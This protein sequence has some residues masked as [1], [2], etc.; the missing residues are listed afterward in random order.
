MKD[1]GGQELLCSAAQEP[2]DP[3]LLLRSLGEWEGPGGVQLGLWAFSELGGGGELEERGGVGGRGDGERR[4][5][6]LRD[7][8]VLLWERTG[9]AEGERG[10]KGSR[11]VDVCHTKDEESS[12]RVEGGLQV[13]VAQAEARSFH[14]QAYPARYT[15]ATEGNAFAAE[16]S[17]MWAGPT[18]AR[19]PD[20][21]PLC[22][23]PPATPD[24]PLSPPAPSPSGSRCGERSL[25]E[26]LRCALPEEL[27]GLFALRA[28]KD[29][30]LRLVE[31]SYDEVGVFAEMRGTTWGN[32]HPPLST[33]RKHRWRSTT[34]TWRTETMRKPDLLLYVEPPRE[35]YHVKM[36]GEGI[37]PRGPK[38]ILPRERFA[39]RDKNLA[40][41][42]LNP[43]VEWRPK[44]RLVVSAVMALLQIAASRQD[45]GWG[46]SAGDVTA[47]F[48]NGERLDRELYLRQ[49]KHGLPGLHPEQLI[50]VEKGI[51]GLID[52]P[53][54]WW[55]QFKKDAQEMVIK[56]GDDKRAKFYASPLDPCVFQLIEVD[57]EDNNTGEAPSC[58]AVVHVDD[59][60]LVCDKKVRNLIQRQ[61][62]E[63]FPVEEWENDTFDFI[64]SHAEAKSEGIFVSQ[65]NYAA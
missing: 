28:T 47:A 54:K 15:S 29:D 53:R 10:G 2:K 44:S 51:F 8:E 25:R 65:A 52:S 30:L 7:R 9:Q 18:R 3:V 17:G 1:W 35:N 38:P 6:R 39:Y 49:P 4:Q 62:S 33:M 40:K 50:K 56:L 36:Y 24:L 37:P 31:Q 20:R 58:Y 27:G 41:R 11:R 26:H 21:S 12:M 13:E 46:V 61:L 64:G 34:S 59:I 32:T 45:A 22:A 57:N 48:L 14:E 60:L 55:K 43:E 23:T 63:C 5:L 19:M 42:W 16:E